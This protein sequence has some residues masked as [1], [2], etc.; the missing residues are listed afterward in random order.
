ML[1]NKKKDNIV[2]IF[3][4]KP[5][6]G[7]VKTRIAEETSE[8]FAYEFS[9]SCFLDLINK[10]N[11][12]DYYDLIVGVDGFDDLSWFQSNFS[13]EGIVIKEERGR[14]KKE[15]QSNKF[16]NIFSTLLNKNG[17]S[18]QK[19]ILIPMDI[20]FISAEDLIAAF[21]RLDQKKF[22][23]GPEI[24]GGVYLIGIRA[25]YKKGVF[26]NVR[27]SSSHSFD[28]LLKNCGERFTFSLKLKNDLN[29]PED[30]ILLRDQ[31]Y[32]NCPILYNFLK[33]NGYYLPIKNKYINFDD[34]SICIPVVSNIVERKNIK[35]H[36]EILIQTRYKPNID[37]KNT[38]KIEIPSGLIKK[39][40]LA[41]D[42]AIRETEEETG[43]ITEISKEQNII[44]TVEKEGNRVVIYRPFYCQQQLKGDRSYLSIVFLSRYKKGELIENY[45]ENRNPR[46]IS[47]IKIKEIIK[48][49]PEK[50]FNLSLSVLKEY[51]NYRYY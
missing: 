22:V 19:A 40:E 49:R 50:I 25:P 46:W 41:Q 12:S 36:T 21:A 7:K 3:A 42:A 51:L 38:G 20:P 6:L 9:K 43:I 28:D 32:N 45:R 16:E 8:N 44:K 31:I 35:N 47:L 13:L 11:N 2:I 33:E 1:P 15:I 34:L 26:K 48:K 39:Y 10:L 18:Y 24:N 14:N 17:C 37:P 4:K 5:E 27:W 23:H 29:A 30:I